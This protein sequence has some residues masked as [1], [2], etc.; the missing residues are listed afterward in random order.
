MKEHYQGLGHV[1]V[2]TR[3]MG[4]SIAFY[5]TIG[6][7]VLR[8]GSVSTPAGEKLLALVDLGGVTLE[9]IQSPTPVSME[10]GNLPHFAI[11]VDDV[12]AAG[13]RS[14]LR[15]CG[16]VPHAGKAGGAG[17]LRRAGKLVFHRSLR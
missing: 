4:Q 6:G 13:R 14:A 9:L 2:Y 3:D 1:A 17:P 12:D 16:Y 5:E 10:E 8:R 11:Y 7:S 15:R